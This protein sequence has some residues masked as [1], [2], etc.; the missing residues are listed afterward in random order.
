MDHPAAVGARRC[1]RLALPARSVA[2]ASGAVDGRGLPDDGGGAAGDPAGAVAGLGLRAAVAHV[3]LRGHPLR[4][5][6]GRDGG[7]V[8]RGAAGAAPG[9]GQPGIRA[10]RAPRR[11]D[12]GLLPARGPGGLLHADP[13]PDGVVLPRAAR[14]AQGDAGVGPGDRHAAAP[15]PGALHHAGPGS[16][17]RGRDRGAGDRPGRER[18]VRDLPRG[19]QLHPGPATP[20]H[21]AARPARPARDGAPCRGDGP[22]PRPPSRRVV[23]RPG[24]GPRGRRRAG[25]PHRA[26]PRRDD[27]GAVARDPDRQAD[28]HEVVAGAALGDPRG[29]RGA[30]RLALRLVG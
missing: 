9:G 15:H 5:R 3:V 7:A 27:A 13:H 6:A 24:R 4:P 26:R 8:L 11:A 10:R 18:R 20:R 23:G 1:R 17:P 16:R 22:R 29:P 21:R 19:R 25:R 14:R 28:H 2:G 30:H 12:P